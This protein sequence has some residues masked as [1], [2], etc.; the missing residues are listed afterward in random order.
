V[1]KNAGLGIQGQVFEAE[2]G[3]L[4]TSAQAGGETQVQHGTIPDTRPI[5]GFGCIQKRLNLFSREVSYQMR[6]GLFHG[7]RENAP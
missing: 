1:H 2:T 5:G 6:I 4:G 3:E 7:D